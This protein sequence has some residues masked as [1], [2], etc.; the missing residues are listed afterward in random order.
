MR[1]KPQRQRSTLANHGLHLGGMGKL[2][3]LGNALSHYAAFVPERPLAVG[4]MLRV[5]SKVR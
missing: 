5:W 1:A 2:A 3:T 4:I